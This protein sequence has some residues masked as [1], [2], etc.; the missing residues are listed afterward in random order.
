MHP[1]STS[2]A[3]S[4]PSPSPKPAES[5]PHRRLLIAIVRRAVLDFA[6]YRHVSKKERPEEHALAI[7]AAGWLFWNGLE[8]LDDDGRY[9]FLYI[10]RILDLDANE[11]RKAALSLTKE[12][13]QRINNSAGEP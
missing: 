8:P 3:G 10:C 12:D 7:D 9:S 1:M 4:S 2:S 5:I 6:I 11:I 13:I